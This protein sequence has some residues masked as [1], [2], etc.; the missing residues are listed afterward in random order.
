[1]ILV[2]L[3][4]T[5]THSLLGVRILHTVKADLLGPT[6]TDNCQ[7]AQCSDTFTVVSSNG[8]VKPDG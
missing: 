1:M 8:R 7:E 5:H 6:P 3:V 4:S 2:V